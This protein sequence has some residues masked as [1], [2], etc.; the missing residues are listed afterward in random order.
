VDMPLAP[1]FNA[2]ELLPIDEMERRMIQKALT[3]TNGNK[4]NAAKMLGI[5]RRQLYSMMDRLF[6]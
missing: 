5:T 2:D 1:D 3:K 6:R 4:T